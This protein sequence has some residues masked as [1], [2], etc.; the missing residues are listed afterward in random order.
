[1]NNVYRLFDD[2]PAPAPKGDFDSLWKVWPRK[3][4]KAIARAKYEAILKGGYRTRTLDKSSGTYIDMELGAAAEMILDGA[5]AYVQSQ[6]DRNTYRLKD[7]GKFIPHLATWL[8]RAGWEDF[9]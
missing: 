1:M 7:D 6:I 3:D 4:G 8:G 5:K 2:P 9:S